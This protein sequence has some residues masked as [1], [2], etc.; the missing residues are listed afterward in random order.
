MKDKTYKAIAEFIGRCGK[1]NKLLYTFKGI[2]RILED[3]IWYNL[4][5]AKF[6]SSWDW[7]MPVVEKIESLGY[8]VTIGMGTY[9]VIQ[10]DVTDTGLKITKMTDNNKLFCTYEAVVEFINWYNENK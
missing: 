1:H 4:S 8:G 3:D 5:E 2:D 10:D 9:V 7:L 6:D